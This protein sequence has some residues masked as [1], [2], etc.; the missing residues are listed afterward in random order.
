MPKKLK[1]GQTIAPVTEREGQ[2]GYCAGPNDAGPPPATPALVSEGP[3]R[4][5]YQFPGL[6]DRWTR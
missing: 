3:G 6:V 5:I 4:A 1:G 2:P